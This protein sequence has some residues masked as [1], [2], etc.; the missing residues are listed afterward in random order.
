MMTLPKP[1]YPYIG[2]MYSAAVEAGIN[3]GTL[4]RENADSLIRVL[5]RTNWA[6]ENADII[7]MRHRG[8]DV[9]GDLI[10]EVRAYSATVNQAARA[11]KA[12][13]RAQQKAHAADAKK[14]AK[15]VRKS[16]TQS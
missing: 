16:S 12:A 10:K 15:A 4:N 11:E 1:M 6:L 2:R 7:N 14:A 5:Q 8:G 3:P 13:M 9:Y